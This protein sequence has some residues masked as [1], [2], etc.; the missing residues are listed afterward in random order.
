MKGSE[1]IQALKLENLN[2]LISKFPKAP[3][4]RF[5]S[6]FPTSQYPSDT[7][8]WEVEYGSAGMTPFVAPGSVAPTVGMDGTGE[9]SAVAAFY[10]EKMYL[11]EEFLNNLR[12][13]GTWA[14]Y[15]TAERKL[16]RGL[17][18]LNFRCD[19][20]R[21]WMLAK[22]LVDGSLTYTKKGGVRFSISYGVPSTHLVTLGT[23]Y[24]WGTGT[25]R[26]PQEDVMD[27]KITLAED[28][29]VSAGDIRCMCNTE[30]L[31]VMMFDS[32]IQ[33][34]LKSSA[35]GNGDLFKSP[36]TVIG[37][38]LGV[39]PLEINDDQYEVPAWI[40]SA[41]TG[42]ST[43]DIYLDDVTDFEVGGKLRFHDMSEAN[44][45]EDEVI[46]AVDIANSYVTVET[47]PTRSFKAGEDKVTMK[48]KYLPDNKFFMFA[49]SYEGQAIGEF[50]EAPYGLGRRWGKYVD[51]KDE[52][53][54]EGVW[55]RVQDKGLPVLYHPDT[56]YTITFK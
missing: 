24:K 7:I 16:A 19:R 11:D 38:L 29:G 36:E 1:G 34:L 54:P 53:D 18:K 23:D 46:S 14:T 10:K 40:T 50:L 42:G 27:G 28:A 45:W 37:T 6:M 25:S 20:R 39:G 4:M 13:P 49:T 5:S 30:A 48:K 26:A 8:R 32:E 55:L 47:A 12:E 17:Q 2:K 31:K 35:F 51:S 22:M 15:Q 56:T 9:G 41:V 43:T 52:W 21:E 33:D 44:V 3:T